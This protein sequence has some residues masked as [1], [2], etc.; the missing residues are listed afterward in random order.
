MM[1]TLKAMN[2]LK[3]IGLALL[4]A[5]LC[6]VA[7]AAT[8]AAQGSRKDD[9]VFGPTGRPMAG[10]S[11]AICTE[12]ATATT[13]PCSPLASLYSDSALTQP[14]ANPL[15][16]DG[17]GNYFFYAAPG[18]YTIEIYGPSVTTRVLPDVILPSDPSAPTFTSVTTT[19]GISA[20]SL[21]LAGNLAV[22]GAVSVAGTLT[23]G[24]VPITGGG[25]GGN[26]AANNAWTG[27]NSF[28]GPIPYWDV[29][30][31]GASGSDA[32]TTC[33]T[34]VGSAIVDLGAA[35]DFVNGEG[36][37][38]LGAGLPS[39]LSTPT[40]VA[41]VPVGT[42]G[43]TSHTYKVVACDAARGC[44]ASASVTVT[45]ANATLSAANYVQGS[46][47]PV[48]NA[49]FYAI[50]KD[51]AAWDTFAAT[52]P[53]PYAISAISN[54]SGTTIATVNQSCPTCNHAIVGSQVIVSGTTHYNGTW[55]ITAVNFSG[56]VFAISWS[57]SGSPASESSGA[58]AQPIEWLDRGAGAASAWP[59][60]VPTSPPS[61]ATAQ[62]LETTIVSGAGTTSL[63]LAN[64][65]ATAVSGATVDHDDTSAIQNA[66]NACEAVNGETPYSANVQGGVINVP[67]GTYNAWGALTM[68][69]GQS[70]TM[71]ITGGVYVAN[72]ALLGANWTLEGL[73]GAGSDSF[74][75]GPNGVF[76]S[77]DD[78]AVPTISNIGHGE[79]LLNIQGGS[80]NGTYFDE[81][82][83]GSAHLTNVQA[84]EWPTGQGPLL[85]F[86]QC[87]TE[88]I[89][90]GSF[91]GNGYDD[92]IAIEGTSG[93]GG[94]LGWIDGVTLYNNGIYLG[95]EVAST[96][97]AMSNFN[98]KNVLLENCTASLLDLDTQNQAIY[99][100][101]L[102]S[103]VSS[104]CVGNVPT[105]DFVGFKN[106]VNSL[107]VIGGSFGNVG[108]LIGASLRNQPAGSS[109]S[110]PCIRGLTVVN[111]GITQIPLFQDNF[112]LNTYA[113]LNDYGIHSNQLVAA[114][115]PA[116]D[117]DQQGGAVAVA[118][119]RPQNCVAT[120][121]L[122][123]HS[124]PD[125]NYDYYVTAL[126]GLNTPSTAVPY[127]SRPSNV[128]PVTVSGG[129][130]AAEVSITCSA[131]PGATGYR[132]YRA[133]SN[134]V[135]AITGYVASSSATM[136]DTGAALTSGGFPGTNTEAGNAAVVRFSATGNH[137]ILQGDTGFG[138]A[139]PQHVVDAAGDFIRGQAGFINGG[140]MNQSAA[141]SD[142]AGTSACASGAKTITFASA[143]SN[144]PVILIF[145]E[146]THGGASLTAKSASSFAVA[147]TGASDAFDYLVIG[148]PN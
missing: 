108:T 40:G 53:Q 113:T 4:C 66:I 70:C 28:K 139:N 90:D 20:F 134:N 32:T 34:T 8:A 118:L 59:K 87:C 68:S 88:T 64:S 99:G 10:V 1:S 48:A 147:C 103:Q 16:T 101:V 38:C 129:G 30:A 71:K 145:D 19:S 91:T 2:F 98:I 126:N 22:S 135:G 138:T 121:T 41:T 86:Y 73:A 74:G 109:G 122:S 133:T 31:W 56:G 107:T 120:V 13:A 136:V 55:T 124:L 11:V 52:L 24:G 29:T 85:K 46:I 137:Y 112:C 27:N 60:N 78:G 104:D 26:L 84:T 75:N 144:T 117:A 76:A 17:L 110:Q 5:M 130:G 82:V 45:N 51:G 42:T 25:G 131:S 142:F 6:V 49:A 100:V 7:M 9:V 77:I 146:T 94:D 35:I 63:T 83:G 123:G 127:Q 3:S 140:H 15:A 105:V 111:G 119:V 128:I 116:A 80:V 106:P 61:A 65:A 79:T 44:S 102:N 58:I 81:A 57:Q 148:N 97:P 72:T 54:S 21:S 12:P 36:L 115:D 23:V 33:T 89:K 47:T 114:M 95:G 93:Q 132:A 69:A 67:Y 43:S 50:Y 141:N 125:G 39:A 18:K 37:M 14:L 92:P 96:G 143:Y 62:W